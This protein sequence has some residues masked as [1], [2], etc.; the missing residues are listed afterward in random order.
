MLSSPFPR[1][2]YRYHHRQH[3]DASWHASQTSHFTHFIG[4]IKCYALHSFC[5]LPTL[6]SCNISS[7]KEVLGSIAIMI[8]KSWRH[9][10]K[11]M[12]QKCYAKAE[13]K[14]IKTIERGAMMHDEHYSEEIND[15]WGKLWENFVVAGECS[16]DEFVTV[17]IDWSTH[18]SLSN[19]EVVE[20]VQSMKGSSNSLTWMAKVRDPQK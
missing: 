12:V 9:G 4:A 7:W 13:S 16:V 10:T 2:R 17:D 19:D 6:V 15:T 11:E 3:Y 14:W 20:V 1:C 8:A 18:A 5:L